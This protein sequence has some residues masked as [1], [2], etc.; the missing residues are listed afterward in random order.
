MVQAAVLAVDPDPAVLGDLRR[1]VVAAG[2]SFVGVRRG[3]D[4]LRRLRELRPDAFIVRVALPDM[5]AREFVSLLREET[6]LLRPRGAAPIL[7]SA[8]R[9]QEDEVAAGLELGAMN[10]IFLPPDEREIQARLGSVLRWARKPQAGVVV[11]AGPVAVDLERGELLRP[12]SQPLTPSEVEV[13]RCLL[14]PPGRVVTRRQIQVGTERAVDVHVAALRSKLGP[15]GRCIET[16]RGIGYR[17]GN[18][19]CL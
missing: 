13:L 3:T 8:L 2:H 4:A 17:F 15:A 19:A 18:A 12:L 14:S 10:V 9:G 1:P 5:C 7:L 11:E 16:L 6:G